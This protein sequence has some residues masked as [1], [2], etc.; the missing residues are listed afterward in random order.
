MNND[1]LYILLYRD[2]DTSGGSIYQGLEMPNTGNNRRNHPITR[3]LGYLHLD[4][5]RFMKAKKY[6]H[7]VSQ[8][9]DDGLLLNGSFNLRVRPLKP[10]LE[11][12]GH[13][14]DFV[15]LILSTI[16]RTSQDPNIKSHEYL[17]DFGRAYRGIPEDTLPMY[18]TGSVYF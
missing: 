2:G 16:L 3:H 1:T 6:Q 13:P 7:K 17:R 11:Q 5:R 9:L 12:Q 10:F 18:L 14:A 4:E 15:E 8:I